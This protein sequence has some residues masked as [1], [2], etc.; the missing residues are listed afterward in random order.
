MHSTAVSILSFFFAVV[1]LFGAPMNETQI[2]KFFKYGAANTARSIFFI[3]GR[4]D[5]LWRMKVRRFRQLRTR[6][7]NEEQSLRRRG[8]YTGEGVTFKVMILLLVKMYDVE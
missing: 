5:R 4:F 2:V 7:T 3:R 6:V 1:V 8:I